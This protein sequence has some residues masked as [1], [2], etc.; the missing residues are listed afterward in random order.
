M[1]ERLVRVCRMYFHYI[2]K[3]SININLFIKITVNFHVID[4]CINFYLIYNVTVFTF[5]SE[6]YYIKNNFL[7]F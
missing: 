4:F 7:L 5:C 1:F 2:Y 3:T 6:F